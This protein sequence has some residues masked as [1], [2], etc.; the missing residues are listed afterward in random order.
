MAAPAPVGM[1]RELAGR[2]DLV[3]AQSR[4]GWCQECMGC[5]AKTAF[6]VAPADRPKDYDMF[7]LEESG[8]CVRL[9]CAPIRPWTTTLSAGGD[10]GGDPIAVYERPLACA[11]GPCKCCC[12]QRVA[13]RDARTGAP[14]GEVREVRYCCV[15]ELQVVDAAGAT[16]HALHQPTAC[17][18]ACVNPCDASGGGCL[19][20]N[21]PTNDIHRCDSRSWLLS[22]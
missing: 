13:V 1:V 7:I 12:F 11:P 9:C 4:R 2:T 17:G 6:R 3:I 10:E 22:P 21:K 8:F 20:V 15:P 16:T 18:G 5:E 14:L 19:P